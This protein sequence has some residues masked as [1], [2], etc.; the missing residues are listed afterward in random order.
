M[1][2]SLHFSKAESRALLKIK[3]VSFGETL[4]KKDANLRQTEKVKPA[5]VCQIGVFGKTTDK[6]IKQNNSLK[7][8]RPEFE[9]EADDWY[10]LLL[11][12]GSSP[13]NPYHTNT[14][15]HVMFEQ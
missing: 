15:K 11:V 9:R 7:Y 10:V 14:L 1:G 2:S 13:Q 6:S 5:G 12:L 4:E 8:R 3:A